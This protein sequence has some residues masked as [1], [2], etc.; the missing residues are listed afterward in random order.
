MGKRECRGGG[1][2]PDSKLSLSHSPQV[3]AEEVGIVELHQHYRKPHQ[4]TF[5]AFQAISGG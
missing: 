1:V 2:K 4:W 5:S 3:V